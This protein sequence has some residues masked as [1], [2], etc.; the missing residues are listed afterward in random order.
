MPKLLLTAMTPVVKPE[1][2]PRFSRC[3]DAVCGIL[4]FS[5]ARQRNGF[6]PDY[7]EPKVTF[8][9]KK[10][11]HCIQIEIA[12]DRI[13]AFDTQDGATI[14]SNPLHVALQTIIIALSA[15]LQNEDPDFGY[16]ALIMLD[17]L[18]RRYRPAD[19]RSV[20]S[21]VEAMCKCK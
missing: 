11:K 15:G 18:E 17:Q 5:G 3:D 7:L 12:K 4:R 13:S 19:E 9:Q 1:D 2:S 20:G 6:V 10:H 14:A 21:Y 8:D 16:D